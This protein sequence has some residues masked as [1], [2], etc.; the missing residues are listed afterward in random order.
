MLAYNRSPVPYLTALLVCSLVCR[1]LLLV[2]ERGD[3]LA[4]E[5]RD[6]G[7]DAAPD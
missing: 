4:A 7:D 6:V 1:L 3:E 5:V 2:G